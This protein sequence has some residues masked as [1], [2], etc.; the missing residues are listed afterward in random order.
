MF[1]QVFVILFTGGCPPGPGEC[2][3]QGVSGHGGVPGPRDACSGGLAGPGGVPGIDPPERLPLWAVGILLECI[4][5]VTCRLKINNKPL[6]FP[7]L[8]MLIAHTH[9]KGPGPGP[10]RTQ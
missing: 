6:L 7:K 1:I 10:S 9:C 2:L 4:L 8:A 3:V 5:V